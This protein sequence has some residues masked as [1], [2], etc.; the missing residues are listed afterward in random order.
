MSYAT[1][2]QAALAYVAGV[3][4]TN[5]RFEKASLAEQ[6]V[7]IVDDVLAALKAGRLLAMGGSY[8]VASPMA[9]PDTAREDYDEAPLMYPM[10]CTVCAKGALFVA[11]VD[12]LNKLK[13]TQG[14]GGDPTTQMTELFDA[15]QLHIIEAVFERMYRQLKYF[16]QDGA[17]Y[18][19]EALRFLEDFERKGYRVE[20]DGIPYKGPLALLTAILHNMKA[21][22]GEFRGTA[23]CGELQGTV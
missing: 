22:D 3:R 2:Y 7:M 12:R 4:A 21:N 14:P 17:P 10:G 23:V 16:V 9:P 5:D 8:I 18:A 1:R 13:I 11:K 20:L 15:V 19:T 6:R